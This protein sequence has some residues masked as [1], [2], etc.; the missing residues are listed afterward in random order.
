WSSDV[1]SS[2]LNG[3]AKYGCG[4]EAEHSINGAVIG[5]AEAPDLITGEAAIGRVK[6][7]NL[8]I[9]EHSHLGVHVPEMGDLE[10]LRDDA[11]KAGVLA[12]AEFAFGG[13]Q[14]MAAVAVEGIDAQNHA[15]QRPYVDAICGTRTQIEVPA[16]LLRG[17]Q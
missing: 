6:G 15:V 4:E 2:D 1:C 11:L 14:L 7:V 16:A 10:D 17:C 9:A 8:G 13:I 12:G 5:E 3:V